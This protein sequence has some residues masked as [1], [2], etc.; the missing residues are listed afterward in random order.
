MEYNFILNRNCLKF[1]CM[2]SSFRFRT[3][4]SECYNIYCELLYYSVTLVEI[5]FKTYGFNENEKLIFNE[6]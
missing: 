5:Y 3:S 1:D 2:T 4:K 6:I